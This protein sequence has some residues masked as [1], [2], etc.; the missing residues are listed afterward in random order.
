MGGSEEVAGL[1]ANAPSSEAAKG[2]TVKTTGELQKALD[3]GSGASRMGSG[4]AWSPSCEQLV[5]KGW[6]LETN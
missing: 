5:L 2:A 3:N 4:N 6:F 1:P